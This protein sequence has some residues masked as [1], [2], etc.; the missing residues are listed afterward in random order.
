MIRHCTLHGAILL[1]IPANAQTLT[2][3]LN[4]PVPGDE[5]LMHT[6][7]VAFVPGPP[8]TGLMWDASGLDVGTDL[9]ETWVDP[10]STPYAAGY[11]TATLASTNNAGLSHSYYRSDAATF[12]HLGDAST[13]QQTIYDDPETRLIFP[14]SLGGSWTDDLHNSNDSLWGEITGLADA[15]GTLVMPYGPVLNV[16][17]VRVGVDLYFIEP[18]GG[19]GAVAWV[20]YLFFKPGV[21]S[22]LLITQPS[23]ASSN[24]LDSAS[25]GMADALHN[26]IGID[27]SPVP[28]NSSVTF[29]CPAGSG[30]LSL[31][32]IAANGAVVR[33]RKI[34]GTGII[35]GTLDVSTL[36][37]GLYD[38]RIEDAR[39]G[40]GSR[41]LIV[42]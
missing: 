30:E 9:I 6:S 23:G 18:G 1:L 34:H 26:G 2:E 10:A 25:M 11:P 35:R 5:F 38:L 14:L 41:R 31:S 3:A 17:R 42:Q 36:P 40:Q 16:L 28:A 21:R 27:I 32:L 4:S 13:I 12:E 20:Q 15:T 33:Q 19:T 39:G 22:P 24:W 37:P 29:T 7:S 8:G